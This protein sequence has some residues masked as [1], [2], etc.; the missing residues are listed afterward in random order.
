MGM[1]LDVTVPTSLK[2]IK[3]R[4]YQRFIK[5]ASDKDVND[6]FIRQKMIQIFCDVPLLA[7]NKMARKDFTLISNALIEILQHKPKLTTIVKLDGKDYGFIPNL[8]QDMTFGEF[9]DLDGYMND[10][11][12]FHKAMGVLYRPIKQKRKE[13]YTIEEYQGN[14]ELAQIMLDLN[15][16]VVLGAVL[17]F[18][19]LSIQ[20]LRITPK[21]L[22]QRLR[23]DP[24]AME[25]LAKNGVGISTFT[26]LLE[27]ACSKL[28]MLL[29]YTLGLRYSS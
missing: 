7:V 19:T 26:N 9:V 10:W 16:E 12:N 22:Q 6:I 17:F 29:P 27:V 14:E 1:K 5:I 15:M 20:L 4:D 3:L 18:W 2:D 28:E 23:K 24:K 11:D 25:V 21:Y 13:N 8:D